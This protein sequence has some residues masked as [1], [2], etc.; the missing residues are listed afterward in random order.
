MSVWVLVPIIWISAIKWVFT[1]F[2]INPGGL[3]F[4]PKKVIAHSLLCFIFDAILKREP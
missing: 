3:G 1:I 2:L 4:L